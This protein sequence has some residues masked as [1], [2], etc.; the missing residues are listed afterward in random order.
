MK[1]MSTAFNL[2]KG[3]IKKKLNR[4]YGLVNEKI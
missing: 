2:A 3:G 4:E 1:T